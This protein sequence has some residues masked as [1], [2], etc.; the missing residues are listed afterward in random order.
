M[1]D[2]VLARCLACGH[3]WT[4]RKDP[5]ERNTPLCCPRSE[6]GSTRVRLLDPDERETPDSVQDVPDDLKDPAAQA[7]FQD[8]EQGKSA[9][10]IVRARG[11]KPD[12]ALEKM[13]ELAELEDTV[14]VD[15]E[16]KE[17][18]EGFLETRREWLLTALE[19]LI[20]VVP[21]PVC[22]EPLPLVHE[23]FREELASTFEGLEDASGETERWVERGWLRWKPEG[24]AAYI[25]ED[26]TLTQY[27]LKLHPWAHTECAWE[28]KWAWDSGVP[29]AW[30]R[31][32][33]VIEAL[34]LT[35][36]GE[37]ELEEME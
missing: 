23:E 35:A 12:V 2:G 31:R 34:R 6:C 21:C 5:E 33:M 20:P 15:K 32:Q 16:L 1:D 37:Y 8:A 24:L 29:K 13:D 7:V 25:M 28:S 27:E 18:I 22:G 30:N 19:E 14:L 10:D 3:E 9:S 11:L 26:G 17:A 4:P 36:P